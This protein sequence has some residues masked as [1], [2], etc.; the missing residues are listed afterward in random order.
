MP[1]P[2]A[3]GE[4][5]PPSHRMKRYWKIAVLANIKD[6]NHAKPEGVPPDA[7]ADFDHIETI[8]ALRAALETDG[9]E[10]VFIEADENLPYALKEAKPDIC[11]NIAEGLGGDAREAQIPA[12]LE[13]LKIPYTGSR[14]LTNGISLD[15]TLTKRIW[16]DR[17]LPVAPFQEFSVGDEPLRPELNFPLFV[18]PAREGTGMGVDTKAIVKNEKELRERAM[19]IINTYQQ[20]AL[21]ETFLPGREFTVGILGRSDAKLYSRHPEWYEK[22]G[23]HRFPILEL[24]MTRSVT[25]QVYSQASKSKDV[26]EEGAP[27][28]ICPA[29]M[30]PELEKKLKHLAL[31][32]HQLLYALD[33]SRT[34]IRLDDEGNP[35]LLEINTL[36]GLTPNYSDLCLQAKAEGIRYE[37]LILDILYLGASRWG[38][39]AP[40]E[41]AL[42]GSKKK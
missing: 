33:I 18:K 8:D 3:R 34:D 10:T 15:K 42:E 35:R 27:G 36:P 21:V 29:N 23:F 40:R 17:R 6:D 20:P 30:E 41:I 4:E 22:D 25:P 13:M 19:Y 11:F 38:M 5:K 12:L 39:V 28:Y 16:R 7:F 14:V 37:D 2:L 31:R 26:G 24:D 32:A 9:H 1:E